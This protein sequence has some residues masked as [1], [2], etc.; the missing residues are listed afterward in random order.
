VTSPIIG[1]RTLDQLDENLAALE[2]KLTPKQM[3]GLNEASKPQ[4]AF[5]ADFVAAGTMFYF[6]GATIDGL[7]GEVWPQ[8]PQNDAERY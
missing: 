6:G 7:R 4:L 2:V 5:P 3:A 1:A 8:A